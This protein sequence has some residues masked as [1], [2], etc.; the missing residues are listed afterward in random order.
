MALQIAAGGPA[1]VV[2]MIWEQL[3]VADTAKLAVE[4]VGYSGLELEKQQSYLLVGCSLQHFVLVVA[5]E[6]LA[7]RVEEHS[8]LRANWLR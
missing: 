1:E 5:W 4:P 3:V 6:E 8:R 2:G 7:E